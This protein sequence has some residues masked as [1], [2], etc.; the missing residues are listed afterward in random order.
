MCCDGP[1]LV[2]R[3]LRLSHTQPVLCDPRC[4]RCRLRRGY[5]P[6]AS[7][8]RNLRAFDPCTHTRR[9]WEDSISHRRSSHLTTASLGVNCALPAPASDAQRRHVRALP[10]LC[11]A[12]PLPLPFFARIHLIAGFLYS[13][14]ARSVAYTDI[15]RF[16]DICRVARRTAASTVVSS[17]PV[18]GQNPPGRGHAVEYVS[19]L[20]PN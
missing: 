17:D 3:C 14:S 18:P 10:S 6:A 8:D 7:R 2:G 12:L 9:I 19:F 4:L 16:R 1:T 20:S 13:I 15:F 5:E 11:P